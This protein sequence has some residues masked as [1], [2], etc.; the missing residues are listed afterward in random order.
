[1]WEQWNNNQEDICLAL[2]DVSDIIV[3]EKA[4]LSLLCNIVLYEKQNNKR[5]NHIKAI[6]VSLVQRCNTYV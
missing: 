6:S 4:N 3:P 5:T 2:N 1:M